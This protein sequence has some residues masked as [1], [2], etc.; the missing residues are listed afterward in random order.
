MHFKGDTIPVSKMPLDGQIPTATARL[1]KRGI[2]SDVPAWIP[3]NCIQCN[4]C[5]MICPHATIRP[6]QID[7]K[8][9]A[10]APATFTTIK[11]TAKN[12]RNLAYRLQVYVE[13]CVGCENCVEVCPT[14]VKALKMIP[15]EEARAAGENA[16]EAF[17]ENLPYEVL[18][19][20]KKGHGQGQS[21]PPAALRV[22]RGLRR[23]RRNAVRQAGHSALR[24]PDDRRQR[25]RLLVHLRRHVP[26]DPLCQEQ[27]RAAGRPGRTP[28]SRTTPN[29]AS[30]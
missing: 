9:L 5:A 6:K 2:A 8:D 13:D 7:P 15:I 1:E 22:Q 23:M 20:L 28:S 19:G 3:E 10:G 17:F 27:R 4:Q 14:K 18:D 11:S 12:E 21:A 24:R 16:N 30:A 29:T 26:D 25:H